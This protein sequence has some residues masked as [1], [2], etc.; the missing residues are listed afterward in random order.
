MQIRQVFIQ[1]FRG[2]Q[3]L[4]WKPRAGLNCLL[5]AGDVGKSTVLDAI[6][7]TLSPK[8]TPFFDTDFPN[9]DTTKT[10]EVRI[11]VG[12]LPNELFEEKKLGHYLRGWTAANEIR[13]EPEDGEEPVITLRLTVDGS[14]DPEWTVITDRQDPRPMSSSERASLGVVRLGAETDSIFAWGQFSPLAKMSIAAHGATGLLTDAYRT[15][16]TLIRDNPIAD[17]I[18]TAARVRT[19]SMELGAYAADEFS[20]GLDTQRSSTSLA[21]LTLHGEGVPVRMSGLGTR[22]LTA[23]AIQR[24]SV[25]EGSIVLIDELEHG[26]EPHRIRHALKKLKDQV[27]RTGENRGQVILTT[28]SSVTLEELKPAQLAVVCE[29]TASL[30]VTVPDNS[31]QDLLRA[32]SQALLGRKIIVCE[33]KTEAGL[34]RG[35]RDFWAA[36]H[37]GEPI[38]F[39]GVTLANAG[40]STGPVRATELSKLGYKVAL[41]RDSDVALSATERTR[42]QAAQVDII[43]WPNS[44]S[45][46]GAIFVDISEDGIQALLQVAY[47]VKRDATKVIQSLATDRGLT[48]APTDPD[49]RTWALMGTTDQLFRALLGDNA[50]KNSYFKRIDTGESMGQIIAAELE[51]GRTLSASVT[52]DALEAWAY[53]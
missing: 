53:G 41:F 32:N 31:L 25:P 34:I 35:M 7:A 18:A 51:A 5:G 24:L 27:E 52:L 16:R 45:T 29:G 44:A 11:T 10:I 49:Y 4:E 9:C 39:H 1:N 21:T 22:R 48:A 38:E 19:V 40:G 13:D 30:K 36:R 28:H 3:K 6:E 20:A 50:K 37:D 17:L 43:E 14:L 26:L 2:I 42:L 23:L 12:E 47:D 46:E 33:G 15:A 8:R